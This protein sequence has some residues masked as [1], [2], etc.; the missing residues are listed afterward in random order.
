MIKSVCWMKMSYCLPCD[1]F[2]KYPGGSRWYSFFPT[3]VS[4][5]FCYRFHSTLSSITPPPSHL[6]F[7]FHPS[8]PSSTTPSSSHLF[9]TFRSPTSSWN[10]PSLC[11]LFLTFHLSTLSTTTPS[12]TTTSLCHL[13]L[14]FQRPTPSSTTPSSC[15]LF[16]ALH[17]ST[18]LF[19][20]ILMLEAQSWHSRDVAGIL[21][22]FR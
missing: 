9:L 6:S 1:G 8:T 12:W 10:T 14:T 16:L 3:L 21:A 11:H 20:R 2:R 7:T 4:N 5:S 17:P 15:H 13:L 18:P 22:P 19:L